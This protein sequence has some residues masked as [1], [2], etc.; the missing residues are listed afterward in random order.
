MNEVLVFRIS[1]IAQKQRVAGYGLPGTG[2]LKK[3]VAHALTGGSRVVLMKHH[4]AVILGKDEADAIAKAKALE[5]VCQRTVEEAIGVRTV[6]EHPEEQLSPELRKACAD[7]V[8]ISDNFLLKAANDGGIRAQLDDIAQMLGKTLKS[9]PND[10]GAI[11]KALDGQDAV[12]VR[13][14]GC[15]ILTEEAGDAEALKL[16]CAKA[17]M[18]KCLTDAKGVKTKLSAFDCK[19]MRF[20]YKKKYS[21]KKEG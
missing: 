20:V 13:D 9:V 15:V 8:V 6:N 11:L 21:R 7:L 19:L 18:A 2:K 1:D 12:L 5:A 3:N 4:G 10:D 14:V 17:A 16:L